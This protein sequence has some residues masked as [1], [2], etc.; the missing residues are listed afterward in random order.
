KAGQ[1]LTKTMAPPSEEATNTLS[2]PA[3]AKLAPSFY[4]NFVDVLNNTSE[5]IVQNEEVYQVLKL[6]EAI[7]EAAETNR[8]IHSI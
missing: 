5:P 7:F 8:T 1:G 3:P 4:N 6:I 2:L